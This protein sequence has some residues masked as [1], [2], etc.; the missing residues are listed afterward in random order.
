MNNA[1]AGIDAKP[2]VRVASTGNQALSGGTA[3][4]TIDGVTTTLGDRVLLKNQTTG[5]QNGVYVVGGTGSAWTL[6]RAV[7][8]DASAEMTPGAFWYVEEG[9]ANG[10]TQWR[11]ENTGT[12]TLGTTSITINQFGGAGVT[13]TAGNGINI[14]SNTISA[15][16]AA[17]GGISVGAGG[18]AL[19]TS[20][21]ARKFSALIGDNTSTTLTVTH[22]LNTQDVVVSV[23]DAG[24]NAIVI[25]DVVAN[26]VNTVQV[27]FASAPATNA[28]R[29]TVLA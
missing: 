9:T 22:N 26:G 29:V 4:P 13:Y 6:T 8:E 3:F 5:S 12:I 1:A 11:I 28:Y 17:S 25:A 2:S 16:A 19:D 20:I 15:V 21:A 27:T 7:T 23:R 14:S 18:I 24:T 10:K